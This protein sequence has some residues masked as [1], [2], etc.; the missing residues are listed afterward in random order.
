MQCQSAVSFSDSKYSFFIFKN[1]LGILAAEVGVI[2]HLIYQH[3]V[4]TL[5]LF[6]FVIEFVL[7][8][9]LLYLS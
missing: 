6:I 4:T 5:F 7:Y 8:N 3:F 9:F 2:S 1:A